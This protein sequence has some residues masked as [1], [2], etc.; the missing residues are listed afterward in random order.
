MYKGRLILFFGPD[1]SGKTT[2]AK[3]LKQELIKDGLKVKISWMR[4]THT[5]SLLL[6]SMLSKFNNMRG[7][8]NPYFKIKAP[9]NKRFWQLLEFISAIPIILVKYEIQFPFKY[10]VIGERSYIDLIVWIATTTGDL[11]FLN[12]FFARFLLI[13]AARRLNFYITADIYELIRR[14]GY[15][16][17]EAFIRKQYVCY[18]V[19]S[20]LIDAHKIDTTNKSPEE[21][22]SEIVARIALK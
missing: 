1:G 11:S 17:N 3:L 12:S 21:S 22:L 5:L 16:V 8:N 19:I 2:L 10:I 18:E 4:G 14:R 7:E 9:R 13:L 6:A 20:E 15:E